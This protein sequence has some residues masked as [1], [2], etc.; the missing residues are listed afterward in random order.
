M[1]QTTSSAAQG[2]VRVSATEPPADARPDTI[3]LRT[4]QTTAGQAA[5]TPLKDLVQLASKDLSLLVRKEVELAKA[6]MA[7]AAK[8]AAKGAAGLVVAAVFALAGGIMAMFTIA[9]ALNEF[10]PRPLAFLLTA[11]I[12]FVLAGVGALFGI[13]MFKKVKGPE[14]TLTTVKDD[15][16]WAKHP[17]TAPTIATGA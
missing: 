5:E 11:L 9:E 12:F 13:K 10:F 15:L 3:D 6:E 8:G 17:T 14:R 1:T 4:V 2:A 7:L 16:A